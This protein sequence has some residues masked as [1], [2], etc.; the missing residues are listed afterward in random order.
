MC[1]SPLQ[2][3]VL[4]AGSG[5]AVATAEDCCAACWNYGGKPGRGMNSTSGAR[6]Y[7]SPSC[8]AW[9]CAVLS[10]HPWPQLPSADDSGLCMYGMP[11]AL[12]TLLCTLAGLRIS[13]LG[14]LLLFLPW[15]AQ[16][17]S[18]PCCPP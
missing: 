6:S 15:H 4:V 12:Q 2:G 1:F 11:T 3:N 10:A 5:H 13:R 16:G 9:A 7:T 8:D 18:G 17:P 14:R